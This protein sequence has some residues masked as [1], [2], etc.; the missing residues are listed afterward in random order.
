MV[1]MLVGDEYRVDVADIVLAC[2][3]RAGVEEDFC[4]F[5]LHQQARMADLGLCA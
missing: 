4:S 5:L 1:L 3:I 2:G